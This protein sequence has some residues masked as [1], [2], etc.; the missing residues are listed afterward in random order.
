MNFYQTFKISLVLLLIVF[1]ILENIRL[2]KYCNG[3]IFMGT[4]VL[5]SIVSINNIPWI[6]IMLNAI[7]WSLW[8]VF[9]KYDILLKFKFFNKLKFL[10]FVNKH[11][12]N[13]FCYYILPT[14]LFLI[15]YS[16]GLLCKYWIVS[17]LILFQVYIVFLTL[18]LFS[19]LI[20]LITYLKY[21]IIAIFKKQKIKIIYNDEKYKKVTNFIFYLIL[22]YLSLI[23]I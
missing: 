9:V 6:C 21:P 10:V 17:L 19:V 22:P 7:F 12:Q 1:S 13:K 23:M 14:I 3:S 11:M 5:L 18:C 15:S 16:I 8:V 20:Y 2:K 4:I